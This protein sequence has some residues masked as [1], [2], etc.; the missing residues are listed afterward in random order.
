[1]GYCLSELEDSE[2]YFNHDMMNKYKISLDMIVTSNKRNKKGLIEIESCDCR[3]DF[4]DDKQKKLRSIR[5]KIYQHSTETKFKGT[6]SDFENSTNSAN[7]YITTLP[8]P[9][10][11]LQTY[12][13]LLLA[14]IFSGLTA[15]LIKRYL[16]LNYIW[17]LILVCLSEILLILT[18]LSQ[19][20][21]FNFGK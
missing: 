18:C 21:T 6:I 3:T 13:W 20:N 1:M 17:L 8:T 9:V 7:V 12:K 16:A 5:Y 4:F 2:K 14:S 19:C 10:N 15:I 11:F